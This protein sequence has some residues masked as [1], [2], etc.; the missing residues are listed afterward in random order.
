MSTT[1]ILALLSLLLVCMTAVPSLAISIGTPTA[2]PVQGQFTAAVWKPDGQG[3]ALSGPGYQGLYVTDLTGNAYTVSDAPL[4]GWRFAWS[5]DGQ[6]LAYRARQ[7]G[8]TEMAMMV[9]GAD[10]KSSQASPYLNDL[11]PPKW[12]DE[13]IT[14]RS[15]DELVT[16]DKDGK[17]KKSYSL[18]QGRGILSR[19]ASV[20]AALAMSHITGATFSGFAS[21]LSTEAANQKAQKGIFVDPDN[22]IWYVDENGEKKKLL[23]VADEDGYFNPQESPDGDKYAVSGLSGD[24]YV[25]DP[26]SGSPA[27]LGQGCNPSWAPDGRG[28]I[29]QRSTDDGHNLTASS[30]WYANADGT[31]LTQLTTDGIAESPSWSPDGSSISYIS[32]GQVYI[33]PVVK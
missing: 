21:I 12:D 13:G 6:S 15:G 5:P 28:L 11:F 3:M 1:R 8:S 18:S 2:L 4:S 9:A 27:S 7:E 30:I 20:S 26:R 23:N 29:F 14:Y 10:G 25:A 17:V 32:G 31:G 22:Q 16:L 19:I 33:A 24:L